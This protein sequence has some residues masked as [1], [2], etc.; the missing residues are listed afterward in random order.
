MPKQRLISLDVFR[1]MTIILMTIVNNPGDWGNVYPPLLHAEW[2]GWTP[3]DLVFPFF[4]FI[5]GVSI[6]F[7][8]PE[9]TLNLANFEKILARSLR[10]LCLG[11]FLNFFSKIHLF[12][13]EGTPLLLIRLL[14]TLLMTYALMYDFKNRTKLYIVLLIFVSLILLAFGGFEDYKNVRIPGVLQRIAIVYFFTALLYLVASQTW[15]IIIAAFLLILYWVLM[16]QVNIPEFGAPNL[17]KATNMSAW[18]DNLLLEGHMYVVSKTWDPEGV[19]STL[20]AIASGIIGLLT[21]QILSQD[22]TKKKKIQNLVISGFL[23]L[24]TG[25]AWDQT[26]PINKPL[27]TSSYVLFVSGLATLLLTLLYWLIEVAGFKKWTTF[28][29][30]WGVNPMIVFFYSGVIPRALGM[31]KV[32]DPQKKELEIS[33]QE[34]LYHYGVVPF[35]DSPF[36]ASLAWALYY[37]V[38]W[39][40]ILWIFF[41]NKLIFKV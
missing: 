27:W 36:N 23:L 14:I 8:I 4:I 9:K 12:G 20:P 17:E 41:R 40:I 33:L 38:F 37:V 32:Q 30:I 39:S 16:T 29:V 11:L 1:G 22:S 26:F 31:I 3:T 28:F 24:L 18:I 21:G 10:I 25:L 2:H 35:Y 19:L 5:V 15:Q 34:Y 7:A 13:L 6:S